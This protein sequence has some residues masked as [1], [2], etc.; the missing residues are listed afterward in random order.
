M[1]KIQLILFLLLLSCS[2]K[3]E[4]IGVLNEIFVIVSPED[5]EYIK[6]IMSDLFDEIIYTPQEEKIFNLKYKDPWSLNEIKSQGNIIL[7]SLEFPEDSTG[8]MLAKRILLQNQESAN[9]IA[10]GDLYSKNQLFSV[11]TGLD[12]INLQ[13]SIQNNNK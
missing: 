1:Q 12:A 8:D 11:F 13:Y 5:K 2:Y 4:S 9:I 6:P 7:V 3:S 10:L